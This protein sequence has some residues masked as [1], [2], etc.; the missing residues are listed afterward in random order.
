ML[1]GAGDAYHV[2]GMAWRQGHAERLDAVAGARDGREVFAACAAAALYRRADWVRAGG[3]DER[4]FCYMEDVDLGFRLRLLGRTC[5]YVPEARAVHL[6]SASAGVG[7]AFS[8]YHGHRNLEWT[9]VKNMPAALAWRYLPSHVVASLAAVAWFAVRGHAGSVL[10]AKRDALMGLAAVLADRRRVQAARVA[11]P[12][13]LREVFDRSP[14]WRRF[15]ARAG[16]P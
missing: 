5:R 2:S 13:A 11:P 8:V 7:S 4:F 14:L 15:A 9:W 3:F 1:D 6:G 16:R 10:R 12:E